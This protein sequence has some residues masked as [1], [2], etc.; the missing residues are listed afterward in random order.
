MKADERGLVRR[1]AAF[2]GLAEPRRELS[3]QAW[4]ADMTIAAVATL[5]AVVWAVKS[6]H[7]GAVTAFP[8]A[9]GQVVLGPPR[10]SALLLL[11]IALTTA[12]RC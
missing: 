8:S 7:G 6:D 2:F 5:A 11:G 10:V 3:Q 9:Y 4:A 12:P 1:L